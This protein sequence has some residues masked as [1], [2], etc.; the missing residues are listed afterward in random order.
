MLK[1]PNIYVKIKIILLDGRK[2]YVY[3]KK[4]EKIAE[5]MGTSNAAEKQGNKQ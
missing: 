5:A 2:I 1:S 4:E 3:N